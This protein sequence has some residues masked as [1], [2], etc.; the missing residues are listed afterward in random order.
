MLAGIKV[1]EPVF[2]CTIEAPSS[3][4]QKALDDALIKLQREDPSL[5]VIY[6]SQSDQTILKG[7]GE[8]HLEA[9]Y[10]YVKE[11]LSIYY[12]SFRF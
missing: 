5:Q 3:G 8:L 10:F 9:R 6:D 4:K 11:S 1:P 7:M 12:L 2:F